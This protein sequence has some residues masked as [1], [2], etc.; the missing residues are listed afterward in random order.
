MKKDDIQ[1]NLEYPD[2]FKDRVSRDEDLSIFCLRR[3]N[4]GL[5]GITASMSPYDIPFSLE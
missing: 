3:Q 5:G 1:S 2:L 4:N